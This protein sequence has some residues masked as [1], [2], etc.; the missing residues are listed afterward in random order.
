MPLGALLFGIFIVIPL[1]EVA[2]FVQAGR[3][4]G[5]WPTL[6][7]CVI[8]ALVGSAIIKR[9]GTDLATRARQRL[10]AGVA[11]LREGFDGLCLVAAGF[12]MI[13]PGFFTDLLGG[14]L[15]IPPARR[16]LYERVQ[17]HVRVEGLEP[18]AGPGARP[19]GGQAPPDV[20]DAEYDV[21]DDDGQPMPP[22]RGR[23]DGDRQD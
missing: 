15:L 6:A 18:G 17:R 1:I 7:A 19:G 16:W 22:P 10:Q 2:L 23:W 20:I 9:Q 11:P 4:F 3:L 21:L 14:L 13:T 8:S 12:L 5:L